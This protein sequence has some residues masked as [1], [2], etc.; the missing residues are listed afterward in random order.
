MLIQPFLALETGKIRVASLVSRP[1][2]ATLACGLSKE[3]PVP[4]CPL[5]SN[6]GSLSPPR[7]YVGV[8]A[9]V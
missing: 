4:E 6:S 3:I 8:E 2:N 7:H 1:E 5:A 9:S